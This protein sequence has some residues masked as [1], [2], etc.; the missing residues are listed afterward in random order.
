MVAKVPGVPNTVSQRAAKSA[1]GGLVHRFDAAGPAPDGAR[2]E[3]H[4]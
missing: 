2:T 3:A 4:T 1:V